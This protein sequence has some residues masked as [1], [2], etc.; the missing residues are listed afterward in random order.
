M[1]LGALAQ[2]AKMKY[3]RLV[4]LSEKHLCVIDLVSGKCHS[5]GTHR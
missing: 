5:L 4:G 3:A 1:I 2:L